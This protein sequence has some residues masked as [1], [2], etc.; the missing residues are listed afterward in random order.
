MGRLVYTGKTGTDAQPLGVAWREVREGPVAE[1][2]G[3]VLH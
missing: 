3:G 1:T 2:H